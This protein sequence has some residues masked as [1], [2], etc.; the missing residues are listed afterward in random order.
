MTGLTTA[1]R[2][3]KG[4]I[5]GLDIMNPV[6]SIIVFQYNPETLARTLEAQTTQQRSR[7]EPLR[8]RGPPVETIRLEV[9]LDATDQLEKGQGAL[10]LH[11]QLAAMEMLLYPKSAALIANTILLA[12]GTIETIQPEA[13]LTLFVYGPARVLPVRLTGFTITEQAHDPGLN[14]IRAK[15][16][17]SLRVLS[18][19]DFPVLH[20]G[21]ALFLVHQVA[22]EVMATIASVENVA[23]AA[24]GNV[25]FP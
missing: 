1:P 6:A 15:A 7:A 22:K 2:V 16:N 19:S 21:Y 25:R 14:P 23:A 18:T 11:P 20:A 5:I 8:L 13:P 12:A 17:L 10:G 4:A 24:S 3:T 9:S